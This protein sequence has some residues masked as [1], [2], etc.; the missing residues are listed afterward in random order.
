MSVLIGIKK[1]FTSDPI[2]CETL[3]HISINL[4]IETK[5]KDGTNV[6]QNTG[7][8]RVSVFPTH[9]GSI[10][11]NFIYSY[12]IYPRSEG[13]WNSHKHNIPVSTILEYVVKIDNVELYNTQEREILDTVSYGTPLWQE[14]TLTTSG[15]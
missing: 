11:D 10:S 3:S 2:D 12:E 7:S 6:E 1:S 8:L 4:S 9:D 13:V 15:V 5:D 14:V